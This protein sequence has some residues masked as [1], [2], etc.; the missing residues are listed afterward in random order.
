MKKII[1]SLA[2]VLIGSFAIAN[3]SDE[4]NMFN[5]KL[6]SHQENSNFK[7]VINEDILGTCYVTICAYDGDGNKIKSWV[8]KFDD[9]NSEEECKQISYVVEKALSS[10]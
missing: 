7:T 3:N 5:F 8:L 2:F 10:F 1:F 9:V 6:L 4:S